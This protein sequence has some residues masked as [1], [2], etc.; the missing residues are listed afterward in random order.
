MFEQELKLPSGWEAWTVAE[1]IGYGISG[2]VYRILN[3]ERKKCTKRGKEDE[4]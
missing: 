4:R 1:E 2:V 3:R